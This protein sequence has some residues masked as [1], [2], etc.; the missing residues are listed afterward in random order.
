M[1]YFGI[2][3]STNFYIID[4]SWRNHK[5]TTILDPGRTTKRRKESLERLTTETSTSE[6]DFESSV[7]LTD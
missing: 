7:G 1:E 5:T 4:N 3:D 6:Y 2:Y